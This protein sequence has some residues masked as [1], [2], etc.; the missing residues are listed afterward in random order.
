[1]RQLGD[2]IE[3]YQYLN[4][5]FNTRTLAQVPASL[6]SGAVSVYKRGTT[7]PSTAGITL[8]TDYNGVTGLND[9]LIDLSAAAFYESGYDYD[10]VLSAGAVDGISVVGTVLAEFSIR[11][12]YVNVSQIEGGDAT[13]Q[14]NA[15]CDTAVS[16]AGVTTIRMGY[17]DAAITSRSS[18]SAAD[19]WAVGTRTLTS[20]G[21][22]VSD[23][24]TAVWGAGTRTLSGFG[25]LVADVWSYATRS[26]TDKAG[27]TISGTKQTL[28]A[29]NDVSSSTVRTQADAALTAYDAPTKAELDAAVA[30]L[31]TS[32]A[33]S[34]VDDYIDTEV[35]AIKAVTDKLDT[36]MESDSGVYRFTTNALENAPTGTGGFTSADRTNLEEIQTELANGGRTDLLI[37]SII[38]NVQLLLDRLTAN[39]ATY[40]DKLNIT[41]AIAQSGEA[42]TAVTGLATAAALSTVAGYVDTEVGAIKTVTDRLSAMLENTGSYYRWL[43]T[44]LEESTSGTG[45]FTSEDRTTLTTV[46]TNVNALTIPSVEDIVD[47]IMDAPVAGHAAGSVGAAIAAI[48]ASSDP[49]NTILPGDYEE[50]TAGYIFS[51]LSTFNPEDDA[52]RIAGEVATLD[53]LLNTAQATGGVLKI[54]DGTA[55]RIV[56]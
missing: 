47:S 23:I 20:F 17:L 11:N 33:L 43:A 12:K 52:V 41:G 27:F 19:V 56:G 5:K 3:D 13:D 25:S 15:A 34:A 29:L 49:W 46:L 16:D 6:S 1:M 26:L 51:S 31:A 40:L 30:P 38:T 32:V 24:A 9:V 8:T 4:F 55:W 36:T 45:G 42:A 50:G 53:E 10:V 22:L 7:T 21:S 39:R 18:H 2:Y 35:T 48:G 14:I 44:A 54:W 28:D 37:D